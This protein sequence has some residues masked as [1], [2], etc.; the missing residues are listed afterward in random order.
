MIIVISMDNFN[1]PIFIVKD[2]IEI[3][4][5]TTEES[6]VSY[7][8]KIQYFQDK[9]KDKE[10]L[11]NKLQPSTLTARG[12]MTDIIFNEKELISTLTPLDESS[13]ILKIGCNY[14]ELINPKFMPKVIPKK[15]G[16]GRK[17]KEKSQTRRKLQGNG[18]YFSS[19]ITFIIENLN[20]EKRVLES[21][22]DIKK[23]DRKEL[24]SNQEQ[25]EPDSKEESKT[26][27]DCNLNKPFK[28]KLFR[29]GVIQVPGIRT[30]S[31]LDLVIPVDTLRKYLEVNF[32][33]PIKVRKFMAV[34][35]NYKTSLLNKNYHVNLVKLEELILKEKND[36]RNKKFIQYM[37]DFM[38]DTH[39]NKIN[40]LTENYNPM[41]IAEITYNTDRCFCL[42][43]KFYRPSLG[44][45]T[46]KTTVK[47]LKKGKINFDGGNSEQEVEELYTW[48][49]NLYIRYKDEVIFDV[50]MIQ[51]VDQNSSDDNI[52]V[53][54]EPINKKKNKKVIK[55]LDMQTN[56]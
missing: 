21:K 44:D 2:G 32:K 23:S 1:K 20:E 35:R 31:M 14:G 56:D 9:I 48:L 24:E 36:Q 50:N 46:K 39:K 5:G 18:K 54:D 17:P 12:E 19:Q 40:E 15:T 42:I 3:Y 6:R 41:N 7:K 10:R 4:D 16:R 25:K 34:M 45:Q 8:E 29:N 30:S 43:I 27:I 55:N 38:D 28:I 52:S 13:S 47:L 26:L 22:E 49:E 51:N 53:Y 37:T 11:F 33:H